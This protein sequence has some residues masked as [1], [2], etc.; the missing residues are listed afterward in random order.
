MIALSGLAPYVLLILSGFLPNEVL[1][2]ASGCVCARPR[3]DSEITA[4]A[5]VATAILTGVVGKI[6]IFCP[7]AL[8][9]VPVT[10]RIGGGV[11][12]RR[13]SSDPP[14]GFA[15]VAAATAAIVAGFLMFGYRCWTNSQRGGPHRS[16]SR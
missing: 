1:A 3:E 11:R 12:R 15:G 9:T 2:H 6:T 4:R 14:F 13:L 5:A 7:G 16:R 10:V 8:A